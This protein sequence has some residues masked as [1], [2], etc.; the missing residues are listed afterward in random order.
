MLKC[1][2]IPDYKSQITHHLV[3]DSKHVPGEGVDHV[4][5]QGHVLDALMLLTGSLQVLIR[6]KLEL[7]L[8]L[9]LVPYL[10]M[11]VRKKMLW[12]KFN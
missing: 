6:I 8:S 5:N 1:Y 11:P 10:L 3:Y 7:K 9:R 2:F 12:H 4:K